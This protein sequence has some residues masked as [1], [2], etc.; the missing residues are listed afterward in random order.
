MS[1]SKM[2]TISVMHNGQLLAATR[3]TQNGDEYIKF[4]HRTAEEWGG[5]KNPQLMNTWCLNHN[6]N[7]DHE[8]DIPLAQSM[9]IAQA[10]FFQKFEVI[11]SKKDIAELKEDTP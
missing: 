2:S 9:K 7:L 1:W 6:T 10:N 4:I 8:C 11:L 5:G 3:P